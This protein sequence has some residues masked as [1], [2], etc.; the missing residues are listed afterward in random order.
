M[1]CASEILSSKTLPEPVKREESVSWYPWA[2]NN[3]YYTA[4]VRL[5]VVPTVFQ[6][7]S[8]IAQLSQAFIAYVDSKAVGHLTLNVHEECVMWLFN[9]CVLFTEGWSGKAESLDAHRGRAFTR[10]AHFGV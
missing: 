10:S 8:E 6:M 7:T 9:D 4:D 2:I 5:C 3:K 1:C